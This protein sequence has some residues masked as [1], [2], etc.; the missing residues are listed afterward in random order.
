MKKI[1]LFLMALLLFAPPGANAETKTVTLLPVPTEGGEQAT[2]FFCYNSTDV[3]NTSGK[4]VG[5]LTKG[6]TYTLSAGEDVCTVYRNKTGY[7]K[8]PALAIGNITYDLVN[9]D[10]DYSSLTSITNERDTRAADN[11]RLWIKSRTS[12]T[13]YSGAVYLNGS[14]NIISGGGAFKIYLNDKGKSEAWHISKIKFYVAGTANAV[15]AYQRN[16]CG[17]SDGNVITS[18]NPQLTACSLPESF[19]STKNVAFAEWNPA[20]GNKATEVDFHLDKKGAFSGALSYTLSSSSTIVTQA[21]FVKIEVTLEK[22]ETLAN[23]TLYDSK[24]NDISGSY[25]FEN[26]ANLHF[27]S[28]NNTDLYN[29]L[30]YY[31]I[32]PT[33]TE[34]TDFPVGDEATA[35]GIKNVSLQKDF[36]VSESGDMYYWAVVN[37]RQSEPTKITLKRNNRV[38][39]FDFFGNIDG[40]LTIYSDKNPRG[41]A[42]VTPTSASDTYMN[43]KR[44]VYVPAAPDNKDAII[45]DV[46]EGTLNINSA[47]AYMPK[48]AITKLAIRT[49]NGSSFNT[50][51]FDCT[52]TT[53]VNFANANCD[54]IGED[55][56]SPFYHRVAITAGKKYK[57][58]TNDDAKRT[59]FSNGQKSNGFGQ[60]TLIWEPTDVAKAP[61][62][63]V[64]SH[65]EGSVGSDDGSGIYRMVD[66]LDLVATGDG[67]MYYLFT[68][69]PTVSELGTHFGQEARM[70]QNGQPFTVKRSWFSGGATKGRLLIQTGV[71]TDKTTRSSSAQAFIELVDATSFSALADIIKPENTGKDILVTNGC[72]LWV[73]GVYRTRIEGG[74]LDTYYAYV[75]DGTNN[76]KIVSQGERFPSTFVAGRKLPA[77]AFV[78]E[79]RYNYGSPEIVISQSYRS[80]IKNNGVQDSNF[81]STVKDVASIT[82]ADFNRKVRLRNAEWLAANNEVRGADGE[83][84]LIYARLEANANPSELTDEMFKAAAGTRWAIEGYAGQVNGK[85]AI[86]PTAQVLP[87]PGT[88]KLLAPNPVEGEIEVI[89]KTVNVKVDA[90]EGESYFYSVNSPKN[91]NELT[92]QDAMPQEGVTL[93]D[94]HF[95]ADKCVL[96]VYARNNAGGLWCTEPAKLT[97]TRMIAQEIASIEE[98]KALFID[99]GSYAE[100]ADLFDED[101]NV[102]EEALE[103]AGLKRIYQL[104]GEAI[105]VKR[106]PKYLY[107]RDYKDGAQA[108]TLNSGN[109][110]LAY[111]DNEWNNPKV[112]ETDGYEREL[113]AGDIVTGVALVPNLTKLGNLRSNTTGFARTVEF[114]TAVDSTIV[115]PIA[116]AVG[117]EDP[118][119]EHYYTNVTVDDSRRMRYYTFEGVKVNHDNTDDSYTLDIATPVRMSFDVFSTRG[120]WVPAYAPGAKYTITGVMLRDGD[121]GKYAIA[122][123]SFSGSGTAAAPKVFLTENEDNDELAA[124][125][126]QQGGHTLKIKMSADDADATVYYSLN[127][128]NPLDNNDP[129]SRIAYTPGEEIALEFADGQD[130]V[131]AMAFA[132][133]PGKTPSAV[134]TRTFIKTSREISYLLNFINQGEQDR[135]YHFNGNVA[136]AAVGGKWMMVRGSVGHYLPVYNADAEWDAEKYL[137]GGYLNDFVI[138]Y[139]E[140]AGN[141]RGIAEAGRLFPEASSEKPED[142]AEIEIVPDSVTFI[143]DANARRF[144]KLHSAQI[145]SVA[146]AAEGD[147]DADATAQWSVT[148][149]A[150]ESSTHRLAVGMLGTPAGD[151]LKDGAM[152]DI[153]GF[154]MLDADGNAEL[155]PTALTEIH[156]T[157]RVAVKINGVELTPV[158][159]DADATREYETVF[160]KGALVTLFTADPRESTKIYYSYDNAKWYTYGEPFLV[161]ESAQQIHAYAQAENERPSAHTHIRLTRKDVAPAVKIEVDSETPGVATVTLSTDSKNAVIYWWTSSNAK[162]AKY[163]SELTFNDAEVVYAYATEEGKADSEVTHAL[164][165]INAPA[166]IPADKISGKVR[167]D[168]K[169]A[170]DGSA[171][172]VTIEPDT[173][174]SGD[175]TIYYLINPTENVTPENGIVYTTPISMTEGGRIMAIL[176]ESGKIAGEPADVNV[177]LIPTGI[178]GIGADSSDSVR[179][180]GGSIIAPE[181]SAVFDITGRR[182][183]ATG[184]RAGIY[185]VRTAD[186]NAVKVKVN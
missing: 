73:T 26:S 84:Y 48:G 136:V 127:G 185:I 142:V 161:L 153:E 74:A 101:G 177:W 130:R 154:V 108:G 24:N 132:A 21:R 163:V 59:F 60:I 176:V 128:K 178:D 66:E 165:R 138:R 37:G 6:T 55:E 91:V 160:E 68:N 151:E 93:S 182:V 86:F 168:V 71:F 94:E 90:V 50:E 159:D 133:V 155:W 81:D 150:H 106:T 172:I 52:N 51:I 42:Y 10:F 14:V 56:F 61:A 96:Y 79:F 143:S 144:V 183:N 13:N 7:T 19:T 27:G 22:D 179:V 28:G 3:L 186:G 166:E 112:T 103:S 31:K 65:P 20:S 119:H 139:D 180:E 9:I 135:L 2:S 173:E 88:P 11:T 169:E 129:E 156:Q 113:R 30:V 29:A 36:T 122:P 137:T 87:C 4:Y 82:T 62:P 72:E 102:K 118:S 5:K 116:V 115:K 124:A 35:A 117:Y 149:T 67:P 33:G 57:F 123:I 83:N 120:G 184:L 12:F 77:G 126:I 40:S 152:Y 32:V 45:I 1:L 181:G 39:I 95:T 140:S 107:L 158:S 164:V 141:K 100:K 145:H 58:N 80:F 34:V 38:K 174:V 8:A 44:I 109:Y 70:I 110:L 49:Q 75:T 131:V 99:A 125:E 17:Y 157:D 148:G 170:E 78:G 134:V 98:F 43:V 104:T 18:A 54:G 46:T 63:P 25:E 69:D 114:K 89:S 15:N 64:I 53:A 146:A 162:P 41:E 147:D 76:I 16:L 97:V 23:A 92:E 105:I 121:T 171:M 85:I 111:N 175:Y 167:F 47:W